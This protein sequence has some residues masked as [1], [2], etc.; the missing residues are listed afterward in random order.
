M[1][2][3][4]ATS[5]DWIGRND[6]IACTLHEIDPIFAKSPA[7]AAATIAWIESA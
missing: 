7:I 1:A 6:S 2:L 4:I 5:S 3:L